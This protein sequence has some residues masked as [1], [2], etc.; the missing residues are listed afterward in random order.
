VSR[1]PQPPPAAADATEALAAE[2]A[3][4]WRR[5]ECLPA[6]HFLGLHPELLDRP[7]GAVRLI[8]EEVCQRQ[9]R[10][11]A[12]DADEIHRRFPCWAGELSVLLDCHRLVQSHLGPPQFPA[13]GEALGD[14]KLIAELG[15]GTLGRVFLA[16]QPTLADRP[17]VL[18]VTP[19]RDREF[20]SL[21]RLQ[22]THIIPLHGVHDF[23][24]RNLRALCQPYL[25]GA[26]LQRLLDLMRDVPPAQRTGRSLV[27]ALD[28]AGRESPLPLPGRGR[29]REALAKAAYPEAICR[30]GACLAE[31]LHYAHE[32]G[33][34]H[35][36]LKPAN[37]LLAA[38]GQPLLLDF[39]LALHPVPAGRPAA[40]GMG[41][42]PE[43]MSPEQ[44]AAFAA[45]RAG[46]PVP[47]AV[48]CRSD[49][50]SLGKLLYVAL[51]GE[52][53]DGPAPPNVR[54]RNPGVSVG[55]ADI[56]RRCLADD[57]KD[58]YPDAAALA[59]DLRRHLA[60]QPLR[61][62]ANRSVAESWR[63]WRRRRPA[64]LLWVAFALALAGVPAALGGVALERMR[65]GREALR[66]GQ[67]QFE[68]GA[69]DEAARTLA[70]GKARVEGL[71]FTKG[72]MADLERSLAGARRASAAG[73]LH[74]VTE[75]LRLLAG[76][77]V[78]SERDL[79]ALEAHCRTAWEARLL[80]AG[81]DGVPRLADDAEEQARAD[82]IDLALL[83]SDLMRR[84]GPAGDAGARAREVLAEAETLCGPSPALARELRAAGGGSAAAG[85]DQPRTFAG[86][87]A[88]GRSLLR[89]GELDRAAAEL[90]RAVEL[91]PQDLWAQFYSGV[92]AYRR[93]RP[94]E[95][96]GFFRVAVALAPEFAEVYHNRALAL[97]ACG[98]RDDARRDYDRA[99]RVA[100]SLAA[101]ALNRGVLHYEAGR[102]EKA[103]ADLE[104]A[105]RQGAD[106]AAA[107]YNLALVRLAL[108]QRKAARQDVEASLRLA[109]KHALARALRE[110]LRREE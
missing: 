97:A 34:V 72:L 50:Y 110:R 105:L 13:A 25:G 77:D 67:A 21:A 91:R 68:R 35:L 55:L 108:G 65:D 89:A 8:Y 20:L 47:V 41:G 79:R 64:S 36:D 23:P 33:L 4:A 60:D 101:A 3:A 44:L 12:V 53:S 45:A 51:G 103:L 78:L 30:V 17:V 56:L 29:P 58:R 63:K 9:E 42:T 1:T 6:E 27:D 26:T 39:H 40:E 93:G 52:P 92:C 10:G 88:L 102:Y 94:S 49:V 48:D 80:V 86:H 37:V 69:Y 84:L 109:P 22:H 99:L 11:E 81:G 16:T 82:L 2:L 90:E 74:G 59:A 57:A 18:K 24:A 43:Y 98:K 70:R 54:R 96:V 61:G 38:D 5:G 28:R 62:V 104:R 71:P 75:R 14:F 83:W 106:P 107:H 100:P 32:R 95:A 73:Q 7:E 76:A 19:T 31:A 85:D 15:R 66:E 87:V 46:K